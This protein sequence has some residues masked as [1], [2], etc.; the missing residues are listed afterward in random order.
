MS[1]KSCPHCGGILSKFRSGPDHRRFFA[2]VHAAFGQWPHAHDFKPDNPEHLR[3]WL[4]CAAGW[5]DV[6]EI[7]VPETEDQPGLARLIAISMQAAIEASGSY[8]FVRPDPNGGR[9]AVYSAKSIAW[10]TIKQSE[11]API[12]SAVEDVITREL[13]VEA[14]ALLREKAA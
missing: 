5:R 3:K 11:F 8:A 9:V 2:L 4:L 12:R 7:A 6:T 13:G 14:D 1:E 10:D